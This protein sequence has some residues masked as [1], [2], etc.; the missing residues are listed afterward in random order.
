MR[1][2]ATWKR[3]SISYKRSAVPGW[4]EA[5]GKRRQ[6]G[7]L[8]G[9]KKGDIGVVQGFIEPIRRFSRYAVPG[10]SAC[11]AFVQH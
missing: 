9:L 2:D 7:L 6:E 3:E 4:P 1:K 11:S 5:A 8:Q 10:T